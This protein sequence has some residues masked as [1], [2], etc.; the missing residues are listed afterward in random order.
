MYGLGGVVAS[1]LAELPIIK[2][3]IAGVPK[4]TEQRRSGVAVMVQY[5]VSIELMKS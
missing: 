5:L 1:T 2:D 4:R 3:R